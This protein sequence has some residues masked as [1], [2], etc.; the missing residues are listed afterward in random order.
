[1]NHCPDRS[2]QACWQVVAV[3]VAVGLAACSP[4]SSKGTMPPPG[5]NGQVDPK[6]AP[7]FISVAG[8]DG[9]V[10]GYV[11]K[12]LLLPSDGTG[13]PE[14]EAWPVYGEDLYTVVGQMVPGKGFVPAGV[15]PATVP[16]IPVRVAPASEPPGEGSGQVVLYVR[17]DA[18]ALASI[19]VQTGGQLEQG[20]GFWGSNIGVG[21][22]SMSTGSRLVLLDRS[23]GEAG[24]SVIRAIYTRGQEAEPPSFW[25][26]VGAGGIISQGEGV[27]QW[28][29]SGPQ[30]C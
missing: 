5:P 8:R 20:T 13:G 25:I 7:D 4:F 17:N 24:A 16:D 22:Y 27:P 2:S 12:E 1:M 29:A 18:A 26:V 9:S 28:W 14:D 21:C 11:R 23:A 30:V 19:A 15:D 10:V 6:S 3:L